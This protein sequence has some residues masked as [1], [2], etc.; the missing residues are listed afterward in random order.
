MITLR[1]VEGGGWDSKVIRWATRCPW[2]HVEYMW[3][4]TETLGAMLQ[5][6]VAIRNLT[7]KNYKNITATE[8]WGIEC[9]ADQEKQFRIFLFS[10]T[11]KPYDW[12]AI[13]SFVLGSRIWTKVGA[14]FC[15]K[16]AA[17]GLEIIDLLK[18]PSNIP[19]SLIT[20]RDV[21]MEIAALSITR[22]TVKL[23]FKRLK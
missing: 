4:D 16:I 11:G 21:W 1:F 3:S 8:I 6:G 22:L 2:S 10:Q 9:T 18:L 19:V 15:S 17:D 23:D 13:V 7:D 20:P 14:W 12:R 5:G